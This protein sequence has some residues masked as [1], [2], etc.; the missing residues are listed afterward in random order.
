[1]DKS[2]YQIWTEKKSKFA[3]LI[4]FLPVVTIC[5][6]L[7]S[8]YSSDDIL[9]FGVISLLFQMTF[10]IAAILDTQKIITHQSPKE[11]TRI[12]ENS[13]FWNGER[14]FKRFY[15]NAVNGGRYYEKIYELDIEIESVKII[16]PSK[17]AINTYYDS[18]PV[19]EDPDKS[20]DILISSI[21]TV[22][23]NFCKYQR[24]KQVEIREIPTF[25]MDFYAIFD[26]K[27]C[28]SGKYMKDPSRR[29]DVGFKSLS[30]LEKDLQLVSHHSQ[31]FEELWDLAGEVNEL[32]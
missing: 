4:I 16:V 3:L 19:V 21:K 23:E 11:I 8:G 17:K 14:K 1:M 6:A 5:Y 10:A 30:W 27:S 26:S 31:H 32:G 28:L 2:L 12:R 9:K 15:L 29:N 22:Y 20:K 7:L 13:Q 18:D 24:V 25:P